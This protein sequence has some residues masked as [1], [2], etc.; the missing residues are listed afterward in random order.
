[1]GTN[2]FFSEIRAYQSKGAY[3]Q[4]FKQIPGGKK[5]K[6]VYKY[7]PQIKRG[8]INMYWREEVVNDGSKYGSAI[9]AYRLQ[10]S[11]EDWNEYFYAA[12]VKDYIKDNP[13]ALQ[14]FNSVFTSD[15]MRLDKHPLDLLK[16]IDLYNEN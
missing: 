16:T 15:K 2:I 6:C 10:K 4:R 7:L 8:K 14:Y 13:K 5:S 1:M 11:G 3:Y 9:T 12:G